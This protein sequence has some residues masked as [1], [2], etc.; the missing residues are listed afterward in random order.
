M[1]EYELLSCSV[2]DTI[3]IFDT[4]TLRKNFDIY[5]QNQTVTAVDFCQSD[6]RILTGHAQGS[7]KV[8]D[9]RTRSKVA[10]QVFESSNNFISQIKVN[11]T[12]PNFFAS[13]DYEGVIKMWDQ[14]MSSPLYKIDSHS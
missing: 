6:R 5:F 7:I 8:F 14:R 4:V 9:E 2:D 11:Q 13:S 3:K 10:Q 1:N 12:S